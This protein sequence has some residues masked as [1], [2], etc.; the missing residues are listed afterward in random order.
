MTSAAPPALAIDGSEWFCDPALAAHVSPRHWRRLPRRAGD[1]L[2]AAADACARQGVLATWFVDGDLARREPQWLRQLASAGH[3]VALAA[4]TAEPPDR[5]PALAR[6]P[7]VAAWRRDR[8]AI[9]AATGV[10][11]RGLR[12]SRPAGDGD[13]WWRT[14]LGDDGFAYDASGP[15]RLVVAPWSAAAAAS[16]ATVVVFPA[17]AF[18]GGQPRLQGLPRAVYAAHYDRLAAAQAAF[19]ALV[20]GGSRGSIAAALGLPPLGAAPRG[21]APAPLPAPAAPPPA[22]PP[23]RLALVVPLK[24]EADGIASLATELAVVREQLADVATVELVLV[25]DGS[26]DATWPL[27][28]QHFGGQ[29]GVQL[30]RHDQNRGVAAAIRTGILATDA[31]LCASIDGDLSYDP[32]ELRAML[33]LLAAAEVVTASP[34]HRRG[35]VRNVPGWRLWLSRSLS[36]AYRLLL[37]RPLHT[38]TSCFRVYRRA[39]VAD[40]PLANP[41]FLGTAELLVRVLRRGG[42]VAE[43][44]CVLEARLFGGSKLRVLRT[45]AGHLRL[46]LQVACGRIR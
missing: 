31:P 24:D 34:Y 3:E 41:G 29:T 19:A 30:V 17:W 23:P 12:C 32:L 45:V 39:A 5:V 46:L 18:D 21:V 7:L 43:H 22:A 35:A 42:T 27:L 8:D 16:R 20:A 4:G 44:P 11:V 6:A 9:E 38:W 2:R 37:R 26:T 28:G 33:P 40:L 13:P 10:A 25:D 15:E 14:A 36:V 1:A